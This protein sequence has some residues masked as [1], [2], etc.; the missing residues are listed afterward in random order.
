MD[1]VC[2]VRREGVWRVAAIQ[3]VWEVTIAGEGQPI[4]TVCASDEATA[5]ALA[6]ELVN[7]HARNVGA[8]FDP[9]WV[10]VSAANSDESR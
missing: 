6:I 8:D 9:Q 4:G 3:R 7:G 10:R 2:V 5:R 1:R